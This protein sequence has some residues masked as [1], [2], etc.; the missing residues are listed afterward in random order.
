MRKQPVFSCFI[1]S[2]PMLSFTMNA[3]PTPCKGPQAGL[4]PRIGAKLRSAKEEAIQLSAF[5]YLFKTWSKRWP[6]A[7]YWNLGVLGVNTSANPTFVRLLKRLSLDGFPVTM[8]AAP[9]GAE[10]LYFNL[11]DLRW[12][13]KRNA[14]LRATVGHHRSSD[15]SKPIP[16][17]GSPDIYYGNLQLRYS[18]GGW[19]VIGVNG[20]WEQP[21]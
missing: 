15:S 18:S 9:E 3:T 14:L 20:A 6:K 2:M 12:S 21:E 5:R 17:G 8:A 11:S 10:D 16:S 4:S 13:S 1:A 7:K 19:K